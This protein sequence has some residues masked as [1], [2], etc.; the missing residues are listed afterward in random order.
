MSR[1]LSNKRTIEGHAGPC[2]CCFFTMEAKSVIRDSLAG[3]RSRLCPS[4]VVRINGL[5]GNHYG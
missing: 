5:V 2:L 4:K 3:E 1:Y